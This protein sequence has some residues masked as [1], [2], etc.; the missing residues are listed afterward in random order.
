MSAPEQSPATGIQANIHKTT[1]VGVAARLIKPG[2]PRPVAIVDLEVTCDDRLL[3]VSPVEHLFT[4]FVDVEQH[5]AV[6]RQ[7]R[8]AAD[9]ALRAMEGEHQAALEVQP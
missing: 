8:D 9:A 3:G 7:L 4:L 2:M 6:L 1:G 5:L